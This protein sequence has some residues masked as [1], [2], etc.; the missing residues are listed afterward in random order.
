MESLKFEGSSLEECLKI[1]SETLNIPVESI[2]YDIL[3]NK[4]G[5]FRKKAV[6]SV[7]IET[8]CDDINGGRVAVKN[9]KIIVSNPKE[10]GKPAVIIP[11]QNVKLIINGEEIR[12]KSEVLEDTLIEVYFSEN[13]P[14]RLMNVRISDDKVSAYIDIDYKPQLVYGLKD[15]DENCSITIEGMVI[16]EKYPP[17][18]TKQEINDELNKIGI[19]YGIIEEIIDKCA[20]EKTISNEQIAKGILVENDTDD[21]IELKFKVDK[22]VHGLIEDEQGR[23]DYKNVGAV[24]AIVKGE[25]VAIKHDGHAGHDGKDVFGN[26]IKKKERKIINLRVGTGCSIKGN[27]VIATSGGKPS[28]KNNVFSV[29]EIHEVPKDVDLSTGNIKFIGDVKINGNVKEGMAVESGN[30]IYIEK[31]VQEAKIISKGNVEIKGNIIFSTITAGGQDVEILTYIE[32]LQNLKTDLTNMMSTILDIKKFNLLGEKAT[33]GEIVKALIENKFKNV[34]KFCFNII[35]LSKVIGSLDKYQLI[36]IIKSK[37]IGMA[38]LEIKHFAELEK[39]I[40]CLKNE[41]DEMQNSISLPVTVKISYAQ[42][43]TISSSGDIFINGKGEY[44]SNITAYGSIYFVSDRSVARGGVLKAKNELKCKT[45]GS[46][47]GVLTRLEVDEKGHIWINEAYQN[48]LLVVGHREFTV[49]I[50][51]RNVHAYLDSKGD[52]IVDRLNL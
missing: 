6:I 32:K 34:V 11:G 5:L 27:T 50:P 18:F 10:N 16:E 41:V 51:S 29:Y 19:K 12:S 13:E 26:V 44:V 25:P 23:V 9:N 4:K 48:T 39:I 52:L 30:S 21:S 43:S 24:I 28:I 3:E 49:E 14:K 37:L 15:K 47:G 31:N 33:D 17:T 42:D 1:A 36:P 35:T 20:V 7:Q 8:V 2:E 45:V 22:D 38:P 46:T 40:E